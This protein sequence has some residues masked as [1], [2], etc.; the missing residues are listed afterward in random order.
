METRLGPTEPSEIL[1]AIIGAIHHELGV[2]DFPPNTAPGLLRVHFAI[3][4]ARIQ[5][6]RWARTGLSSTGRRVLGDRSC[7]TL[8]RTAV[9]SHGLLTCWHQ[10]LDLRQEVPTENANAILVG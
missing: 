2:M 9:R 8:I 1:D 6:A 10:A 4:E 5:P 3:R 7:P